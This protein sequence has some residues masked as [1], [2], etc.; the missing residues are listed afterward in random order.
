MSSS[1]P[2]CERSNLCYVPAEADIAVGKTITWI[3]YD[4]AFH[5]VTSGFYDVADGYF[6]SGHLE[7]GQSFSFT[8]D[9]EGKFQYYCKLHPWMEG[10]VQV[11][12]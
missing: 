5:T 3:N 1:R 6:D 7:A 8:F 10:V 12:R 4:A 2:G 11:S 9:Q